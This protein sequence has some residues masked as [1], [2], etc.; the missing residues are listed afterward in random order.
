MCV[1]HCISFC[2]F[3]CTCLYVH[4]PL[5]VSKCVLAATFLCG[6]FGDRWSA[7]HT[8]INRPTLLKSGF[9]LLSTS[10]LICSSLPLHH[11][12]QFISLYI[13]SLSLNQQHIERE[14]CRTAAMRWAK[15]MKMGGFL[16]K[17]LKRNKR[18][19]YEGQG[20]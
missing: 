3:I 10:L 14:L 8:Q 12:P 15:R 20:G 1:R 7:A 4:V 18:I 9:C 11:P 16:N 5:A 2:I 13:T 19:N 17:G 6:S